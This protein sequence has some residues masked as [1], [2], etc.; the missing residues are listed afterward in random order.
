MKIAADKHSGGDAGQQG[1]IRR[2]RRC[3]TAKKEICDDED[4][5]M[6]WKNGDGLE[7]STGNNYQPE[8]VLLL[9]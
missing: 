8:G 2:W 5:E 4:G 6:G 1:W 3:G 9:Q 7:V